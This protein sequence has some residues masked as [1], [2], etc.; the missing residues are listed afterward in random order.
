V[1]VD[2]LSVTARTFSGTLSY[3]WLWDGVAVTGAT[4]ETYSVP[5]GRGGAYQVRVTNEVG[6]VVS[7]PVYVVR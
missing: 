5:E 2:V 4:A 3:Q 6:T 1:N 7:N